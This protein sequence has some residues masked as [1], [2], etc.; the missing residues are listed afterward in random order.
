MLARY[1]LQITIEARWKAVDGK[2]CRCTGTTRDISIKGVF[3]VA[4]TCPPVGTLV[5]IHGALRV[6]TPQ[7]EVWL[8]GVGQVH[9]IENLGPAGF[10]FAVV[11]TTRFRVGRGIKA[12]VSL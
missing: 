4:N 11:A 6:N 7:G 10:G 8:R 2:W 5:R 12:T 9:R 1:P 3:I